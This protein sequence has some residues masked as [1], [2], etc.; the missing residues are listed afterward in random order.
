MDDLTADMVLEII[1]K[2]PLE[3]QKELWDELVEEGIIK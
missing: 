2:L 1:R 3:K